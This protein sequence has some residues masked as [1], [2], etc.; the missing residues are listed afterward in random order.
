[1]AKFP[2]LTFLYSI[3][4]IETGR[5]YIGL[6][7]DPVKRFNM[8]R[9]SGGQKGKS[10][11]LIHRAMRAYGIDE[12]RFDVIACAY[13]L[14][15]ARIAEI[16]L[17]DQHNAHV[18]RGGFN[19]TLGGEGIR[20]HRLSIEAREKISASKR[21]KPGRP[22]TEAEKV[23]ARARLMN[24]SKDVAIECARRSIEARRRNG[25]MGYGRKNSAETLARMKSAAAERWLSYREAN[26]DFC[27]IEP[28]FRI[29]IDSEMLAE[30]FNPLRRPQHH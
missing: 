25:N 7:R 18:S 28:D 15:A 1:M 10:Q 19:L 2:E 13:D 11:Q 3:T 27:Q 5:I 21:G 22:I 24:R 6:A 17:I 20:G 4:H 23:A 29:E 9:W 12:F 8:H 26:F 30:I 16:A 14:D